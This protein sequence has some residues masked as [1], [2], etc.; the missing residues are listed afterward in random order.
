[1]RK[2]I[3][4]E[5]ITLDGV[6]EA[7]HHWSFPY[8]CDEI[9]K[10]KFDETFASHALLLGRVTYVAFAESWPGRSDEQGFADRFNSLPK[11]VVSTT[12]INGSWNNSHIISDNVVA[13][14]EKLKQ[15]SGGDLVIHGSGKLINSLVP[16]NV[17]DEYRLLVYPIVLGKGQKLFEDGV[18]INLQLVESKQYPTGVVGLT[19]LPA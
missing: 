10:F 3:V 8:G 11:Y 5:F 16:A 15:G 18:K 7:P 12:L 17:I 19:Y 4:T 6:I 2:V 13:Q 9:A 14:I 1:M